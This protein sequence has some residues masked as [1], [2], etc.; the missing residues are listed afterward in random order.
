V[1]VVVPVEP[2]EPVV[3]VGADVAL[4]VA[5]VFV[6]PPEPLEVL[7]DDPLDVPVDDE[8]GHPSAWSEDKADWA[9]CRLV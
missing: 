1:T 7:V 8:A 3:T 6:V 2:A 9:V 4:E 5:P